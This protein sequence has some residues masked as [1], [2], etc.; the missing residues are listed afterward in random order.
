[1]TNAFYILWG[2]GS[3]R[4]IKRTLANT[5]TGQC[6]GNPAYMVRGTDNIFIVSQIEVETAEK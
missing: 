3:F 5:S 4:L 1:M 6:N 2:Q